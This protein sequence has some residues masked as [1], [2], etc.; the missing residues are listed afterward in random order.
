MSF[1]R[2][3]TVVIGLF[4]IGANRNDASQVKVAANSNDI[5]FAVAAAA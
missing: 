3:C 5:R 2:H 4:S 1:A